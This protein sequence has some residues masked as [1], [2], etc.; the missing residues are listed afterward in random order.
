MKHEVDR[1]GRAPKPRAKRYWPDLVF[2]V[3]LVF[4]L[5]L[6]LTSVIK[7]MLFDQPSVTNVLLVAWGVVVIFV[8]WFRMGPP[9]QSSTGNRI[10]R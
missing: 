6:G 7:T 1:A 2:R 3:A 9:R 10:L 4:W 8:L 5:V